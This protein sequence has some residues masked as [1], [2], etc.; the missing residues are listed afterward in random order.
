M[1]KTILLLT[2]TLLITLSGCSENYKEPEDVIEAFYILE[3]DSILGNLEDDIIERCE[4]V[5]YD[6][7]VNHCIAAYYQQKSYGDYIGDRYDKYQ[8]DFE[9][10][11][12]EEI[13][14]ELKEILDYSKDDEIYRYEVNIT[15]KYSY[16]GSDII[17][18]TDRTT[19]LYLIKID[20][21]YYIIEMWGVYY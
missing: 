14:D 15:T 6:N 2:I 12:Y 20:D 7:E 9:I 21:N 8:V 4:A 10:E 17:D 3:E 19:N 13:D 11:S 18:S 16:K 1:K 5:T